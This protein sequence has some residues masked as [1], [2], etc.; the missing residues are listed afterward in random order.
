MRNRTWGKRV[1]ELSRDSQLVYKR[2]LSETEAMSPIFSELN[3]AAALFPVWPQWQPGLVSLGRQLTVLLPSPGAQKCMSQEDALRAVLHGNP[4]PATPIIIIA[5]CYY[6]YYYSCFSFRTDLYCSSGN[7]GRSRSSLWGAVSAVWWRTA[8]RTEK[9]WSHGALGQ[10]A[11]RWER[12][13]PWQKSHTFVSTWKEANQSRSQAS[14]RVRRPVMCN[15]S[16]SIKMFSR[17]WEAPFTGWKGE[18]ASLGGLLWCIYYRSRDSD[19]LRVLCVSH[20]PAAPVR[21]EI[22]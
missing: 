8:S 19:E 7:K 5:I 10:Y 14:R 16:W 20:L 18:P 22:Y 1:G 6:Y 9:W 2:Y 17:A 21:K 3:T 4:M 13:M 12:T 11:S 15:T